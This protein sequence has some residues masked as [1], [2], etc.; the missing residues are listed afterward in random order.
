[1]P[2]RV[3]RLSMRRFSATSNTGTP[4]AFPAE[5]LQF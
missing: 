1:V 3:S 2:K 5:Y 4:P